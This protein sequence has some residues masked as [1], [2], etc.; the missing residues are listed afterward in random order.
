MPPKGSAAPGCTLTAILIA[1]IVG[2]LL[3]VLRQLPAPYIKTVLI[4]DKS[5]QYL[6]SKPDS[7]SSPEVTS[8]FRQIPV[9]EDFSP[10]RD[11][12]WHNEVLTRKGGFLW[13]KYNESSNE[14]WGI[15]MFHGLH[16]LKMLRMALQQ[17]PMV[18]NVFENEGAGPLHQHKGTAHH[19][20][21]DPTHLGHCVGYIA[22]HLLCAA[23]DTLEPPWLSFNDKG[24]VIDAGVDGEGFRHK[25]RDTS[26]LWST[27]ANSESIPVDPWGWKLDDTVNGVFRDED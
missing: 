10:S 26:L 12:E 13:V 4:G 1:A 8:T 17:S 24:D 22:Q 5:L 18:Q 19:P 11:E 15:S 23:D 14:A 21:M 20:D 3:L 7:S 9:L 2:L 6:C 27:A 25:C 16:C